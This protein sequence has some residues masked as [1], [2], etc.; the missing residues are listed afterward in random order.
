ML[1]VPRDLVF[2]KFQIDHFVDARGRYLLELNPTFPL[3]VKAFSF[4]AQ[5]GYPL[6]W[7][8][9]L[10]IFVAVEGEVEFRMGDKLVA[11]HPGD[12]L[13]V[14][15]MKLHGV[16]GFRGKNRKAISISFLPE[17]AYRLGSPICDF[18]F[19]VPFYSHPD[20]RPRVVRK[21]D[22]D[23]PRVHSAVSR[24]VECYFRAGENA[25]DQAG[26]HV[27]LLEMLYWLSRHF[28]V[29]EPEHAEYIRQQQ[30][31]RRLAKLFEYIQANYAD[32]I[33]VEKGA[34]I[35]AMSLSRFMRFFKEA[36]GMTFVSYLTH[37]R[38]TAAAQL[39]R[40]P[41]LSIGEVAAAAGF[42]DQSYFGRV[43]RERAGTTPKEFRARLVRNRSS[44]AELSES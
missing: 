28:R 14:E 7:H 6:N 26:C 29:A 1:S 9:R 4:P 8:E 11:L 23:A 24:L 15:N 44:A 41:D 30:R 12:L 25:S 3:S 2:E 42:P 16:A 19:L 37:V 33:S 31:T 18:T 43:F 40:N 5:D 36:A 27:Y 39:L 34:E 38:V 20:P 13:V 22:S 32:H 21:S 10:E 35:T 17:L